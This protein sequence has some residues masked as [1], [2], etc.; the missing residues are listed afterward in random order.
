[1]NGTSCAI[2]TE[3]DPL[4]GAGM[5]AEAVANLVIYAAYN[6]LAEAQGAGRQ[7]G[8]R[9][10]GTD[11]WQLSAGRG[12]LLRRDMQRHHYRRGR[13]AVALSLV[14]LQKPS[15]SSAKR[16]GGVDRYAKIG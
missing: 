12:G 16:N 9:L 5:S 4:L 7:A 10:A 11:A 3:R 8:G 14:V 6:L 1:M 13:G 2:R 15:L